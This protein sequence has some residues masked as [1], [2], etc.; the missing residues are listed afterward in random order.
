MHHLKADVYQLYLHRN[1]GGWGVAQLETT[2]KTT[3]TGLAMYLKDSEDALFQL[4]REHDRRNKLFSIQKEAKKFTQ[5][6]N[7]PN[8]DKREHEPTTKFAKSKTKG[9]T[10]GPRF[11]R[12]AVGR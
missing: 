6:L 9:V 11:S 4:V 1:A 7:M 12:K 8:L 3:K 5:E 10:S 2:Y